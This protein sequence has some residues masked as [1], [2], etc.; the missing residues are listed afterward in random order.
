MK[1]GQADAVISV[2]R[3]LSFLTRRHEYG[4]D[5]PYSSSSSRSPIPAPFATS[6]LYI[7]LHIAQSLSLPLL[8][9]VAGT[10]S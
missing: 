9:T 8:S 3:S 5:E 2:E 6:D 4:G 1:C 10:T 7:S